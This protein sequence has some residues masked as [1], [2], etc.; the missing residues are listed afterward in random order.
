MLDSEGIMTDGAVSPTVARRRVRLT[1]REA[2]E[3]AGYT[4]LQV[5]E[6]MEWSLSKVI[7]IEN[8]DVSIAPNDLRVLLTY[9][10]IRDKVKVAAMLADAKVARTR[11]AKPWWNEPEYREHLSEQLRKLIEYEAEAREIRYYNVHFLPGP[12]Q[13]PGY[14]EALLSMWH[15]EMSQEQIQTRLKARRLRHEALLSR[16][17]TFELLLLLDESVLLRPIGG[18]AIFAEQLELLRRMATAGQARIR[19][20][21]FDPVTPLTNN[22]SF[23]IISLSEDDGGL[24]LYR[25]NGLTDELVEDRASTA[26]HR[27]RFDKVWNLVTSEEETIDFINGRIGELEAKTRRGDA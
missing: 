27:D 14:G 8:G 21:P 10:G 7:R 17:G 3:A 24:L 13:T 23:D 16:L 4:Q 15:D 1:L 5:A 2:R 26:R 12:L 6:D 11:S 9:L 25:E 22:A 20:I 19:M 18:D